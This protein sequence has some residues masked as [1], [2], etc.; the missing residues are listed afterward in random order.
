MIIMPPAGLQNIID[1]TAFE[2]LFLQNICV[3]SEIIR[4]KGNGIKGESGYDEKP[5]DLL[6]RWDEAILQ[7]VLE[8]RIENQIGSQKVHDICGV[9]DRRF[10]RGRD[11][12]IPDKRNDDGDK[13]TPS[14]PANLFP[15][16]E[17]PDTAQTHKNRHH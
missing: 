14:R 13:Q 10:V 1:L 17:C 6:Q 12:H 2:D 4:E 7:C 3:C 5:A 15:A 9:T 8:Q 11:D 16:S